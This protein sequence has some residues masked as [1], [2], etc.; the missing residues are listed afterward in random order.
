MNGKIVTIEYR[1]KCDRC[2]IPI[3]PGEQAKVI[4]ID[5]L[6]LVRFEHIRCPGAA[7]VVTVNLPGRPI[8]PQLSTAMS[9]A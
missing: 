3:Q 2:G 9:L 1:V 5:R 6:G 4:Y 7:A 8:R